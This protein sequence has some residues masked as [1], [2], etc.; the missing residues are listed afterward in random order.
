MP[1]IRPI[2]RGERVL[3]ATRSTLALI[4]AVTLLSAPARATPVPSG[5]YSLVRISDAI[6]PAA[7]DGIS[8][9]AFQPG[10]GAHLFAACGS[11]GAIVRYDLD[12]LT[13]LLA[14][15]V[16]VASGLPNPVG[17]A[18]R[19]SVLIVSLS[20]SG[21][22]R[23]A[24]LRDLNHDGVFEERADFVRGIPLLLHGVNQV[25][26]SGASLYTTIGTETNGGIPQYERVYNGTLVRIANLDLVTYDGVA[27]ALPDSA[28]FI[29]PAP[30]DGVLRRFAYGFRNPFGVR[31]TAGGAVWVSDNGASA[32]S[33]TCS[34]KQRFP[35]DTPDLLYANVA[36]G[37]K[38]QF[39][40][41]GYPGGGGA[42]MVPLA[43]LANHAATTGFDWVSA[44]SDSG[45]IVLT[46]YGA[47]DQ[48]VDAGR[49]AVAVN[50]GTG[51]WSRVVTGFAGPT[52]VLRDPAGRLLISDHAGSAIYALMP[53]G[54]VGV[55][56]DG[57]GR[58]GDGVIRVLKV[59]PQPARGEV[60]LDIV[61]SR[62]T[63]LEL[64]A[65]HVHGARLGRRDL[66]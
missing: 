14:N 37:A 52:D 23:L 34:T 41:A 55:V 31:V 65:F 15:A 53:P 57:G 43:I 27:N 16:T 21:E 56:A 18:F 19:D 26:I 36:A 40:P 8:Q 24:R 39:P 1:C 58:S 9:L 60:R 46:E 59:S 66:G 63:R 33:L 7:L 13:G 47:S 12:P 10:D 64:E 45:R 49:D 35:I 29:N 32:C 54:T 6:A 38:G 28:T 61:L 20:L 62:A 51:A 3:A 25:Q 2:P 4:A 48:S 44:G 50:P 30:L 11:A 22:G 5:G 42:T 17:L